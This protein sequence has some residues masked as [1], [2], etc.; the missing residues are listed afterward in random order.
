MRRRIRPVRIRVSLY[1]LYI[2]STVM[3][4]DAKQKARFPQAYLTGVVSFYFYIMDAVIQTRSECLRQ[5]LTGTLKNIVGWCLERIG[6]PARLNVFE[7]VD[8]ASDETVY[9]CTSRRYSIL[10]VGDRRFYFDRISGK[11][12]G[13]SSPASSISG[14]IEFRD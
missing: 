10:C 11:F 4:S 13:I 3:M 1:C 9:L 6:A 8:P 7:F 5:H 14:R 2:L 12:D